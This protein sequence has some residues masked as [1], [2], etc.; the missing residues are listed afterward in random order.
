MRVA[1]GRLHDVLRRAAA[2]RAVRAAVGVRRRVLARDHSAHLLFGVI[3]GATFWVLARQALTSPG[4]ER[5]T[6]GRGCALVAALAAVWA[7]SGGP[8]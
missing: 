8:R 6:I 1:A 5:L 4:R 3:T 2:P 7:A